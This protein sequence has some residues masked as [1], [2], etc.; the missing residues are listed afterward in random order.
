M[1]S[2]ATTSAVASSSASRAGVGGPADRRC[3]RDEHTTSAVVDRHDRRVSHR[4]DRRAARGSAGAWARPVGLAHGHRSARPV[5]LGPGRARLRLEDPF[6]GWTAAVA[7]ALLAL[8]LR[9][10]HLGTP[11]V[12]E[13][14][15]TYYAK[16]AWSLLNFGYERDSMAHANDLILDGT[17]LSGVYKDNPR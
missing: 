13:F 7:V 6:V 17:T 12:F 11:H 1:S 5:G 9:L 14:D 3:R 10:W 16:D 15:E 2:A 4:D 8:F